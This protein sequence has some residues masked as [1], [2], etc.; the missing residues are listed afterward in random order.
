[1]AIDPLPDVYDANGNWEVALTAWDTNQHA[2]A[3]T[4]AQKY[5]QILQQ[6][7]SGP[8]MVVNM[9]S[10]SLLKFLLSKAHL[11][12]YQLV[13]LGNTPPPSARRQRVDG[14]IVSALN[15]IKPDQIHFGAVALESTGVRFYG[16]YC[17]VLEKVDDKTQILDRDSYELDFPPLA[18]KGTPQ[19][20]FRALRGS[21]KADLTA[22]AILKARDL[23]AGT[24]RLVTE[25]RMRDNLLRGE[26]FIEVHQVGGFRPTDLL[27]I[28]QADVDVATH[29]RII[30]SIGHG[31]APSAEELVWLARRRRIDRELDSQSVSTRVVDAQAVR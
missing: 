18:D 5:R 19:A 8:R 22:M 27:E 16:E 26:E 10:W 28:R 30:E 7:D 21:W 23:L 17:L 1:M 31:V 4:N 13:P 29:H 20:F 6:G 9:G 11:N 12:S 24:D 14:W 15:G 25:G 3:R 2:Y